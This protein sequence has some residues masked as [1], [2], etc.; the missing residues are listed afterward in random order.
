VDRH[1]SRIISWAL[2]RYTKLEVRDY[3]NLLH[4]TGDYRVNELN[5]KAH[6]WMAA[7]SL[8]DLKLRD[9]G[10]IILGITREDGR[11]V[12]APNGYTKV[13]ADDTLLL[14][15][16]APSL[17]NLDQRQKGRTGDRQHTEAAEDQKEV[18]EREKEEE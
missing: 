1:L 13:K 3:A 5:V 18:V 11:Y 15:G 9:E 12:G 17:E 4:L 10:I 7:K 16:R 2:K 6:D 14:Y 8:K